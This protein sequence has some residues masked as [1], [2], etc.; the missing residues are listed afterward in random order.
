[1]KRHPLLLMVLMGLGI[2]SGTPALAAEKDR[3]VKVCLVSGSLEYKSDESLARLQHFLEKN[4]NIR[5]SRAF[6]Q[7]DKNLP[8]LEN[9]DN[10]D[11]AIFFTRRLTPTADQLQRVQKYCQSGKPIIGLRT[12]SHGFQ[13]WLDFDREILG[14]NYRG[15]YPAGPTCQVKFA[16]GAASHPLLRGVQPFS[17]V[18]SLYKNTGLADDTT[19]LLTGSI[20]G[21]TEPI[22]WTR[23]HKGGRVF[24]TSLGHP[25]DFE[26]EPFLRLLVNAIYWTTAKK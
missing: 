25:Q 17:S 3:P 2:W 21:H 26:N 12:A 18:A 15:H 8:G 19:V 1:M 9:L 6:R 24:Y 14:G 16:A 22:A 10:C 13:N 5:C 7:T 20:P 23:Q 4:Y 11:V